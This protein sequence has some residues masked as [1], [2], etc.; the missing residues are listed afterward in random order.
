MSPSAQALQQSLQNGS[1]LGEDYLDASPEVIS[2][3]RTA[4][5]DMLTDSLNQDKVSALVPDK[6]LAKLRATAPDAATFEKWR[7]DPTI[8]NNEI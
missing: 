4:V 6:I 1:L 7:T 3:A 8:I 2:G 5:G